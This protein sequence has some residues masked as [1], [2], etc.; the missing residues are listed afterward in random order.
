MRTW[1]IDWGEQTRNGGRYALMQSDENWDEED[2]LLELDGIAD[3][4]NV[5]I[6]LLEIPEDFDGLRYVEIA[7]V[8]DPYYGDKLEGFFDD[9]VLIEG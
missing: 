8:K 5:R 4:L 6:S 7:E 1:I 3:P 2:V 9:R